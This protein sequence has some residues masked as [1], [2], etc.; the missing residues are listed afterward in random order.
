MRS[1]LRKRGVKLRLDRWT[2]V[3]VR[4]VYQVPSRAGSRQ[5]PRDLEEPRF[6]GQLSL[7]GCGARQGKV[8]RD[9][10]G[11]PGSLVQG[12]VSLVINS[13]ILRVLGSCEGVGTEF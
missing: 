10:R 1:L 11:G 12:F 13:F 7:A 3:E 6:Q 2:R 5:R 8:R 4:R 9:W